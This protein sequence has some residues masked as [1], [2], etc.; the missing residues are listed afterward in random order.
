MRA[1]DRGV[2]ARQETHST[3]HEQ[4]MEYNRLVRGSAAALAADPKAL[5]ALALSSGLGSCEQEKRSL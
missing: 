1:C 5:F 2:P 4:V 3:W